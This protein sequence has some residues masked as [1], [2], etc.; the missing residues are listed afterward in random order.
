[1]T[2]VLTVV[3]M[4]SAAVCRGQPYPSAIGVEV[5]AIDGTGARVLSLLRLVL[6]TGNIIC[7]A[8]CVCREICVFL[9][10]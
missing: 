10:E 5:G 4:A 1:M 6:S 2:A 3:D 7:L 9:Q 8:V